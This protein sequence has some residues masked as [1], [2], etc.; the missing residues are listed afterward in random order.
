MSDSKQKE[1]NISV[2]IR[3]KG[4]TPEDSNQQYSQ[5]KVSK[6]NTLSIIS[7]KKDFYYDY[8]GDENSTQNDIFNCFFW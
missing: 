3:I 4:K 5:I 1:E 6:S 7:K 2:I 8:I